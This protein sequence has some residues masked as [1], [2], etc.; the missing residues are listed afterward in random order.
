MAAP[1]LALESGEGKSDPNLLTFGV[2]TLSVS[3]L[4]AFGALFG[5]WLSLRSGTRPWPPKGVTIENYYGTTLSLTMFFGAAAAEWASWAVKKA[6]RAQAIAA[7]VLLIILGLSFINLLSYVVHVS[8]FGPAT[9]PYGAV[10]FAFNILMGASVAV[11]VA[12]AIVAFTR[13][14]GGQ[15]SGREPALARS[16]AWLWHAATLGWL[17]MYAAVYVVS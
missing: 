4:V 2:L 1:M 7:Y 17:V 3:L 16:A 12:A 5:A 13:Y 14:L 11:A 9:H 8:H 15:V 6:E 10:Y